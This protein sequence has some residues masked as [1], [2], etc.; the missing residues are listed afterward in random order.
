[1]VAP[2]LPPELEKYIDREI[3]SGKYRSADE[4]I[5]EALRLLREREERLDRLRADLD[6]GLDQIARG[7][8]ID[9]ADEASE[10]KFFDALKA[11]ITDKD[12]S[13]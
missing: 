13:K 7:E 12:G 8:V 3:A 6:A 11:D 2:T 5:C 1:M 9:L 4:V 10:R